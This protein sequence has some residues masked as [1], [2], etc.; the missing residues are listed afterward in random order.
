MTRDEK[1]MG[2]LVHLASFSGYLVPLGSI[3][4]PLIVWLMK[5]D[6]FPFVESCGRNCLNFK[7]SMIIYFI[8]SGILM[9]VGIGFIVFGLLAIFDIIVTIIA[10]IKASE[11]ESYKYP[12]T[13]NFI[14][15]RTY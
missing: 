6:E 12:L 10:A 14:K 9:L 1:N 3:L 4:G 7:I 2:V 15:P 5:R 8:I 11:G 13:I